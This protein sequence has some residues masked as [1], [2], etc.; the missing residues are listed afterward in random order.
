MKRNNKSAPESVRRNWELENRGAY[1]DPKGNIHFADGTF[2]SKA[3]VDK[4]F[5]EFFR[6]LGDPVYTRRGIVA[7]MYKR[8][9]TDDVVRMNEKLV[10]PDFKG[11]MYKADQLMEEEGI[12]LY[13]PETNEWTEGILH[14]MHYDV[15][16][17]ED[18]EDELDRK[19]EYERRRD[20][21]RWRD[22]FSDILEEYSY[23]RLDLSWD[24]AWSFYVTYRRSFR[25]GHL[26]VYASIMG[27][28]PQG[29]DGV[30]F[31]SILTSERKLRQRRRRDRLAKAVLKKDRTT[32]VDLGLSEEEIQKAFERADIV[33]KRRA[34]LEAA[35]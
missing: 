30:P 25:Q 8:Y 9:S 16:I 29:L 20:V 3:K 17:R 33:L 2:A 14:H 1:T 23:A 22:A 19:T 11:L 32:L 12:K 34:P 28:V 24:L 26:K 6:R 13:E 10:N 15:E 5:D 27:S 7:S 4:K 35:D 18:E 31:Q 21:T